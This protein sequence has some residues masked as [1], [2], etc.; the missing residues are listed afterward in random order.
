MGPLID[1]T[2]VEHYQKAIADAKEQGGNILFGGNVIKAEGYFV[3][4]TI[5]EAENHWESVQRETFAPILYVMK[6]SDL[7]VCWRVL[8][9][10]KPQKDRAQELS[11][12]VVCERT[13]KDLEQGID[14]L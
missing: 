1:K 12:T 10:Q 13:A 4:P 7:E 5:I 9:K 3:E 8:K 6:Y 14:M 11:E 2:S